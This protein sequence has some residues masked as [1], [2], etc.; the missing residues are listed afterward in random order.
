MESQRRK[1]VNE[2]FVELAP[3]MTKDQVFRS[4]QF[5]L[6]LRKQMLKLMMSAL[7]ERRRHFLWTRKKNTFGKAMARNSATFSQM[8]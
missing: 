6:A 4:K 1:K 3:Q 8:I 2:V 7:C 5:L